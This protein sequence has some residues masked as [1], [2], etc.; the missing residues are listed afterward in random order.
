MPVNVRKLQELNPKYKFRFS[1]AILLQ[2]IQ[3]KRYP[4]FV[5]TLNPGEMLAFPPGMIHR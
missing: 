5:F 4:L 3:I 2:Q 1:D